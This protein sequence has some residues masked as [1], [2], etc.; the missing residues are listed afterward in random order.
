MKDDTPSAVKRREE[1]RGAPTRITGISERLP[2][3]LPGVPFVNWKIG[4]APRHSPGP[5]FLRY[6]FWVPFLENIFPEGPGVGKIVS[7]Y[8]RK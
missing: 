2:Y 7:A 6:L 4:T 3:T 1:E 8:A 5:T